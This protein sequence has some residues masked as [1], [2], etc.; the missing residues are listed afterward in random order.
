[1]MADDVFVILFPW[2]D[3]M[4]EPFEQNGSTRARTNGRIKISG[5][6]R[7]NYHIPRKLLEFESPRR[8]EF[9]NFDNLAL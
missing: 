2:C 9:T 8:I 6:I 1:M 4:I 5:M 3:V 7:F